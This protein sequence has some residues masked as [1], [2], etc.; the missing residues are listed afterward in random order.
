MIWLV[1]VFDTHQHHL[2]FTDKFEQP[3]RCYDISSVWG[4]RILLLVGL[5]L[6]LIFVIIEL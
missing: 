4:T 1:L 3:L 5:G 2:E 6:G